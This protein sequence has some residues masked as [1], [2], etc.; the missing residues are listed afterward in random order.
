MGL[1]NEE[2]AQRF[3]RVRNW[4][5]QIEIRPGVV[6]PGVNQSSKVRDLLELPSDCTG[7]RVLDL[8]TRDGYFAFEM[9]RRGAEVIA[10]DYVSMD[11]TGFQ[12]V[13]ELL[14]S[15]VRYFQENVYNVTPARFGTFDIV[16]FLGLIYHLPDPLGA[17]EVIRSVCTKELYLETQAIDQAFMLADGSLVPLDGVADVLANVPIMQY[18]A[19]KS[20]N[21]DPSNYWAPNA[22]CMEMMLVDSGFRLVMQKVVGPR[23]IFKCHVTDNREAKWQ[24]TQRGKQLP[25]RDLI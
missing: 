22:K 16:L 17:L 11:E 18:Y 21:D 23:A 25:E 20:L 3:A 14:D 8:G 1:S 12:L 7:L 24:S 9:E 5:H 15:K 19:G 6:T 4:Y 13:A 2:I 10:I